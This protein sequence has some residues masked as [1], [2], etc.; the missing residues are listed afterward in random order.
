MKKITLVLLLCVLS[1]NLN[2][3]KTDMFFFRDGATVRFDLMSGQVIESS[4]KAFNTI[5][6][7]NLSFYENG[8]SLSFEKGFSDS[9]EHEVVQHPLF[10]NPR[11]AKYIERDGGFEI[12]FKVENGD[13]YRLTCVASQTSECITLAK[14][15]AN[16][17]EKFEFA[18]TVN[19]DAEMIAAAISD[20]GRNPDS[21][22]KSLYCFI[23]NLKLK[24]KNYRLSK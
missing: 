20:Y 16:D 6:F 14:C 5:A 17:T 8:I 15:V 24:L 1:F 10:I 12:V 2:A 4:L 7:V 22:F 13:L 23:E 9:P 11:N 3:Q 19:N 21:P 18:V